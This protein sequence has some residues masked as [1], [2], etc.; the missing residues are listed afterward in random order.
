MAGEWKR[1]EV[2]DDAA[3]LSILAPG[4]SLGG[5]WRA[6]TDPYREGYG[7]AEVQPGEYRVTIGGALCDRIG[8][9]TVEVLILHAHFVLVAGR[10]VHASPC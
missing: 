4:G 6:E 7:L 9:E 10:R 2:H 8:D 5:S 3:M 1:V